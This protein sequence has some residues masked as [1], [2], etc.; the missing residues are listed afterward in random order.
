MQK[1]VLIEDN[2]AFRKAVAGILSR[3]GY[4]IVEVSTGKVGLRT[5]A[6]EQP[7]LVILDLVL[8]GIN[9]MEVCQEL[10]RSMETTA[11]PILILTGNDRE[12]Q[13]I[14]CLDVGADDY[15]TKPV[16]TERLLAHCR[17]LLRRLS[18]EVVPHSATL[19]VGPM[20]L[21][22]GAKKVILKGKAYFHLTPKEFGLLYELALRTPQP[23]DRMAL[24]QKVWGM[25]PPSEGSLKTVD[26]HVR[27]I[28]IKM[29]FGQDEWLSYVNGRGY[30]LSVPAK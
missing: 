26:V 13:D 11:I 12:G 8:P 9:G 19:S 1:I 15:L 22:F 29:N 24:Y 10:K 25:D 3:N 4:S 5:V 7:D 23:V 21:D 18:S 20:E 6:Q 28:R 2:S 30:L 16:E 14:A 17:A 27:R